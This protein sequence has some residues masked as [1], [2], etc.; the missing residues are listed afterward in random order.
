VTPVAH[1]RLRAG[2]DIGAVLRARHQRAGRLAVVHIRRRDDDGRARVAVMASRRV[3]GAVQRNRAKRLLREAARH[4]PFAPGSD[5]VL[6]ARAACAASRFGAVHDEV[7]A[8]AR[9]LEALDVRDDRAA[10]GT[11]SA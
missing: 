8:S 10:G 1:D 5:V 2:G 6:V 11:T 9:H 3:G 7:R 4:V